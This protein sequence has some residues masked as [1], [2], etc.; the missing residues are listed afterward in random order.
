MR[1]IP[2]LITCACQPQSMQIM[3]MKHSMKGFG[4]KGNVQESNTVPHQASV[5]KGYVQESALF[6]MCYKNFVPN[7]RHCCYRTALTLKSHF[8]PCLLITL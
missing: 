8:F 2:A 6:E 4:G 3:A 5:I 7:L 1:V